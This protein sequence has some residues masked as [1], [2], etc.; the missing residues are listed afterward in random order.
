MKKSL[1]CLVFIFSSCVLLAQ[2]KLAHL[3]SSAG[4]EYGKANAVDEDT[5][6]I[7]GALFQNTINVSP[8]GTVNLTASG[9]ATE[10]AL[11]KYNKHGQLI[12][13]KRIGGAQTSEAPHGIGTDSLR[14]IYVAGYF[15]SVATSGPVNCSFNPAGGGVISTQGNEDIF[16]AKYD[17]AGNY[18]WAF[19]MGNIGANTQE[20]AWDLVTDRS[21][22]SYVTGGFRGKMNFNPL[23]NAM[24]DSIADTLNHIFV[25]KYNSNGICQWYNIINAQTNSV[26]F[27][28]YGTLDIDAFGNLYLAGN[29]RGNNV[30]LNRLGSAVLLN[31]SGNCDIFIARYQASNG[32]LTWV[33]KIGANAQDLVS[34]GALRCDLNGNPYFTGRLAGTGTVDFDPGTPIVNVANSSLYMASFDS[35]GNL[36]LA[37]GMNSGTGDGGHR[38]DFDNNNNV[39]LAGWANGTINFGNGVNKTANSTTADVFLAK[40]SNAGVCQWANTF[41]GTGSSDNNICAG[42]VVDQE[43]NP[44]ITGQ[45]YGVNADINP[46]V[47]TMYLSSVGQNDCFVIK[48][49]SSGT[50]WE[51]GGVLPVSLISFNAAKQSYG[52]KLSWSTSS[53]INSLRFDIERAIDSGSFSKIGE[54]LA[55]GNTT[56]IRNYSFVDSLK[57]TV[58]NNL[59]YRL[60][61]IDINM[62]SEYSGVVNISINTGIPQSFNDQVHLIVNPNPASTEIFIDAP[63]QI[64]DWAIMSTL[65]KPIKSGRNNRITIDDLAEGIYYVWIN[66][67]YAS[68]F[69]I[70]H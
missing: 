66:G 49:T 37:I 60:K 59:Y 27:E 21:G 2:Q 64:Q 41:G 68:K 4:M 36:R 69:M 46:G 65:G 40:Y 50:L 44:I 67:K 56:S 11:T 13:A 38:I 48:Y 17:S 58:A 32:L 6:Y 5:N 53:E 29:F 8:N 20:R 31:S 25:A 42:L 24:I 55:S 51:S 43:N 18:L 7:N 1:T 34:P 39:Y 19:G 22:N 30:N 28:C 57:G 54:V 61:M 52:V 23:G 14:N 15:G 16:V 47:D 10:M 63:I 9:V 70:K 12:W 35:T 62:D 26:F 33:K 45:L 3:Y